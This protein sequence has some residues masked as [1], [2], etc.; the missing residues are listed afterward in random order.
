M[1]QA[2]GERVGPA[3]HAVERHAHRDSERA[4][5]QLCL[6]RVIAC[7]RKGTATRPKQR[8]HR[9]QPA[10]RI[11]G[12]AGVERERQLRRAVDQRHA[13]LHARVVPHAAQK[14]EAKH[15]RRDQYPPLGTVERGRDARPAK[16][17]A[18]LRGSEA[19]AVEKLSPFRAPA[20]LGT[21]LGPKHE[22]RQAAVRVGGDARDVGSM[23]GGERK[24]KAIAHHGA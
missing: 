7:A 17:D 9:G 18:Q 3:L 20:Q 15:P 12:E 11:V 13:R 6:W 4:R 21:D 16:A 22:Q 1:R 23:R 14:G 19:M 24:R 10:R 2:R 5:V 8:S